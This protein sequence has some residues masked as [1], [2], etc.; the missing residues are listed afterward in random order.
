MP[1]RYAVVGVGR[2]EMTDADFRDKMKEAIPNFSEDKDA[3]F[4]DLPEFL[5]NVYYYSM[6]YEDAE[7]YHHLNS[8]LDDLGRKTSISMNCLF[9]F[10]TPPNVYENM[11]VNLARAG[12]AT[13]EKGFRRFI[14][15]KPFG[16]DL[17]SGRRLNK[18][19][20]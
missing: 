4:K 5:E 2:T 16:F 17:E 15:E 7:S 13:Q 20:A 14:I 1:D 12:M 18:K 9:Y 11:A 8:Y 19:L 3:G 10:A 6:D